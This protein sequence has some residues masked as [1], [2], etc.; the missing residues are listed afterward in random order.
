MHLYYFRYSSVSFLWHDLLREVSFT[1]VHLLLRNVLKMKFLSN[2]SSGIAAAY[3]AAINCRSATCAVAL[4]ICR[5]YCK[6]DSQIGN[7]F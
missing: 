1:P 5:I 3:Q 2:L 4:L 6:F 7:R